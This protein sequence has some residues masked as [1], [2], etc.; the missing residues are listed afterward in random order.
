MFSG[1]GIRTLAL[2][3]PR[4][5]P[6]SY[7]NGSVWAHDN[8][9]TALGLAKY[10]FWS[11]LE[12]LVAAQLEAAAF[13]ADARLPELFAGF[14]RIDTNVIVPYPAACHPQAWDAAAPLAFLTASS[15]AAHPGELGS[16]KAIGSV[17]GKVRASAV[18]HGEPFDLL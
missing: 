6:V 5:N 10:G 13:E 14:A 8:A 1:W 15:S 9:M 11:E 17:L 2:E 12:R 3:M 4:Y 16:G 18:F 7:H